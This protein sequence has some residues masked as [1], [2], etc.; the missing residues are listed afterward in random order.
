MQAVCDARRRF[1]DPNIR[2]P[3]SASDY[4]SFAVSTLHHK[5]EGKSPHDNNQPFLHPGLAVYA[6]NAYVN[7]FYM[8]VLFKGASH[9]EKDSFNFYH[10]QL[11]INIEC[12]F[13]MLVHRWGILRKAMPMGITVRKTSALVLVL[14]K[15]HNFCIN[16]RDENIP[17]PTASDSH[18]IGLQGG[19]DVHS[20]SA[21]RPDGA[22]DFNVDSS[23]Y[24]HE[25]E[26]VNDLLDG[27]DY[28]KRGDYRNRTERIRASTEERESFP[29]NTM[30]AHIK[31]Q[32]L[33][34]PVGGRKVR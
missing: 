11:R 23:T 25:M 22:Q 30:L 2:H 28:R 17:T 21:T 1:L 29:F 6:D 32:G 10:S 27:G 16:E 31:E 9:G 26:R 33:Q 12:A 20:F 24:Q 15:L 14:C 8:V 4:L 13:G 18:E 19:I 7:T 5:L 3:G 34:R